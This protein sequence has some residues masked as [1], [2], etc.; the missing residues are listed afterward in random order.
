MRARFGGNIYLVTR[1]GKKLSRAKIVEVRGIFKS[2]Y[3]ST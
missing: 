1:G 3:N 2:C